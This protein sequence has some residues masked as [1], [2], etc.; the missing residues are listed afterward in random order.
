MNSIPAEAAVCP[1]CGFCYESY[2]SSYNA[3]KPGTMLNGKYLLGRVLGEGGFGITYVALDVNLKTRIAIKEFFPSNLVRRGVGPGEDGHVMVF[4]Q[5][6]GDFQ[7]GLERYVRE[8]AILSRF[9]NLPGIVSVKDFF[10]ENNTAY[11]V[12][13]Y[14]DGI[15]LKEYLSQAGGS[16]D[17]ETTLRIMRPLLQSLSVIHGAKIMHRD[18]SPDNIMVGQ[19]GKVTLIDFGAARTFSGEDEGGKTV[20]V[21]WGYAPLEQFSADGEQGV[22][23]DIYGLCATMYKMLTGSVPRAAGGE[24]IPLRKIDRSVPK[25]IDRAILKGLS[26]KPQDRQQKIDQL[27]GE[28]YL[29]EQEVRERRRESLAKG[30][31]LSLLMLLIA[32]CGAFL[33]LLGI[34]AGRRESGGLPGEA[35]R[36]QESGGLPGEEGQEEEKS[37]RDERDAQV[38][39]EDGEESRAERGR[40]SGEE[41]D[42]A[43]EAEPRDGGAEPQDSEAGQQDGEEDPDSPGEE[44]PSV[45]MPAYE[46]QQELL[47]YACMVVRDGK[48]H[49][50]GQGLT[51]GEIF[52]RCYER[53]DGWIAVLEDV[54]GTAKVYY[55][56]Y[57][58]TDVYTIAFQ[59]YGDDTWEIIG[60]SEN[61]TAMEN[62][63]AYIDSLLTGIGV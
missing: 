8:A 47:D 7:V 43:G 58:G 55:T 32:A 12:M 56:G 37:L 19:D 62:Y 38:D 49:N 16:L 11:I 61:G 44:S 14:V 41:P 31:V 10:Y 46:G 25:Y 20:M 15:S 2:E 60:V 1:Y 63:N 21:K 28:L 40:E 42:D 48:F 22:W 4:G 23:T 51:V 52:D 9:F 45:V 59:V 57:A 27:Y 18:I 26:I 3:L 39:E 35:R 13:E 17:L 33:L 29:T 53:S 36:G 54:D 5:R 30:A 6:A 50:R 24:V 34:Y